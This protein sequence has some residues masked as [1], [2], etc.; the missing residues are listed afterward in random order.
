MTHKGKAKVNIAIAVPIILAHL[1]GGGSE[2]LL[3]VA[4][5]S[6]KSNVLF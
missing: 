4:L 5:D 1:W 6:I 3:D 2:A